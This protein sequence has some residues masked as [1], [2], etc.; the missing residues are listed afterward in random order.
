MATE[1][2]AR[3]GAYL[4][5]IESTHLV[6]RH[7][8]HLP[9]AEPTYEGLKVLPCNSDP[10]RVLRAEPTYE[11]LKGEAQEHVKADGEECGA[12]LRG[13]ESKYA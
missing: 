1:C 12:Y 8:G 6:P 11:G 4:R 13:I 3:C 2:D 9:G 5:G 7:G 10:R